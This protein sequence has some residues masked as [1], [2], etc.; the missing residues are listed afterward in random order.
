[1]GLGRFKRAFVFSPLC[2]SGMSLRTKLHGL[3]NWV[4]FDQGLFVLLSFLVFLSI[5]EMLI[6]YGRYVHL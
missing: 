2:H 5:L 6:F 4:Q 1:M 3:E